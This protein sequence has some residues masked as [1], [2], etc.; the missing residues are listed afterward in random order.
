MILRSNS[1]CSLTVHGRAT[2]PTRDI[3]DLRRLDFGLFGFLVPRGA[4][5]KK[6]QKIVYLLWVP[7]D[8]WLK[9][10]PFES[11]GDGRHIVPGQLDSPSAS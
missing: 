7:Y 10:T 8:L 9:G 4:E 5:E 1:R 6:R 2:V 3:T 11:P